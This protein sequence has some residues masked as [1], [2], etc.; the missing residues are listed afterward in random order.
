MGRTIIENYNLE[1]TK[2]QI[3]TTIKELLEDQ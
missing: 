3:G 2:E 1:P